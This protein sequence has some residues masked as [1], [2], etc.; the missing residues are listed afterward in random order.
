MSY[1]EHVTIL[2]D[3]EGSD[4]LT[5]LWKKNAGK[6]SNN[7]QLMTDKS[8]EKC[9]TFKEDDKLSFDLSNIYADEDSCRVNFIRFYGKDDNSAFEKTEVC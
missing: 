1:T 3:L 4:D 5:E 2:V 7:M 8:L 6:L 9:H